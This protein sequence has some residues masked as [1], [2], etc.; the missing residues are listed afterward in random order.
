MA[1][2]E[3]KQKRKRKDKLRCWRDHRHG[4]VW[5]AEMPEHVLLE[6]FADSKLCFVRQKSAKLEHCAK[7][8][9]VKS[10][11]GKLRA[12]NV[13]FNYIDVESASSQT[14]ESADDIIKRGKNVTV[15]S[16]RAFFVA[17]RLERSAV[18]RKPHLGTGDLGVDIDH[19]L[20]ERVV[21]N[22][23]L[24]TLDDARVAAKVVPTLNEREVAYNRDLQLSETADWGPNVESDDLFAEGLD[25]RR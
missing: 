22:R 15:R 7:F 1:L 20:K 23:L 19:H 10:W 21:R 18:Q 9:I 11:R 5:I 13:F 6:T 24:K 3:G 2:L 17:F 25:I 12:P 14:A 16:E 4:L 8:R